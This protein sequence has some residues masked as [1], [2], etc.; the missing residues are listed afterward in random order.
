NLN[1]SGSGSLIVNG[2]TRAG[3]SESNPN[4][5]VV[6]GFELPVGAVITETGDII[7]PEGIV[8]GLISPQAGPGVGG[9]TPKIVIVNNVHELGELLAQGYV[10]IVVD[11]K[12]D[13]DKEEIVA[14]AN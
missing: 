8:I 4:Q 1:T 11:L 12:K 7:L 9:T 6:E 14:L 2:K 13:D 3:D 10:A 5:L